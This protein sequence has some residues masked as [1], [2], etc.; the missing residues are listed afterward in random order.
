M[1]IITIRGRK[2]KKR[3]KKKFF[4]LIALG[5][6]LPLEEHMRNFIIGKITYS[7]SYNSI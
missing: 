6:R 2:A 4:F 5:T 7:K 1:I 3:A